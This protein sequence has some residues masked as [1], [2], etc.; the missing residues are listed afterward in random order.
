MF[1]WTRYRYHGNTA[2]SKPALNNG[3]DLFS[4]NPV[5]RF[6]PSFVSRKQKNTGLLTLVSWNFDREISCYFV[7]C[8]FTFP[9]HVLCQ[10]SHFVCR[11]AKRV[12]NYYSTKF[13]E[14]LMSSFVEISAFPLNRAVTTFWL[15]AH[16]L[17]LTGFSIFLDP[18]KQSQKGRVFSKS[19]TF[20]TL[21]NKLFWHNKL[22]DC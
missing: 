1:Y 22:F 4:E 18:Y 14:I 5:V 16:V 20:N 2:G 3:F 21:K 19:I 12:P 6:F 15:T 8:I 17:H 7:F 10:I 13:H 9:E 11:R